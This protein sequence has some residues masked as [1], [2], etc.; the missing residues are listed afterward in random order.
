[1]PDPLEELMT[2]N[3]MAAAAGVEPVTIRAAIKRKKLIATKRGRDWLA[4]RK[5]FEEYQKN[6]KGKKGRPVKNKTT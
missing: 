4:T 3:E 5:A 6:S 1:M 2:V